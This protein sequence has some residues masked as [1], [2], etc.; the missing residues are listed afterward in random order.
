MNPLPAFVIAALWLTPQHSTMPKGISHEEHM[1]AMETDEALKRRGADAMGFDQDATIH[2]FTLAAGGG[3]IEVTVR[4]ADAVTLG[5]VRTHL[6]SI[7]QEFSRGDFGKPFR[8]HGQVPPG[9]QVM[10][11]YAQVISYRYE[12]TPGGGAVRIRTADAY[13]LQAVHDY[14]RYQITEHR[15]GDPVG[16]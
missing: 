8:T 6:T 16:P 14:L 2:H 5:R 11:K 15:T 7:A 12:D 9:V 4:E 10:R 13:A 3:S 1:A